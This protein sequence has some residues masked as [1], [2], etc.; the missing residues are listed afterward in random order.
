MSRKPYTYRAVVVSVYDG[1]TIRAD[2]DLGFG[3]WAHRRPL[4]LADIDAPEL[5]GDTLEAGR[6][7]RDFL[8]KLVMGRDVLIETS[9]SGKYGRWLADVYVDG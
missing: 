1:D 5:R 7:A 3:F 6:V 4:R 2:I 8:K 9:K